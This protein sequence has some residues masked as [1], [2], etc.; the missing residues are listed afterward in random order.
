MGFGAR[1]AEWS[2]FINGEIMRLST[3]WKPSWQRGSSFLVCKE[4][5]NGALR[6]WGL[7]PLRWASVWRPQNVWSR[8]R[9]FSQLPLSWLGKPKRPSSQRMI[10]ACPRVSWSLVFWAPYLGHSAAQSPPLV[11]VVWKW[12]LVPL[13]SSCSFADLW[14]QI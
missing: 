4:A 7:D 5:E 14:L 9:V 2:G 6:L 12:S 11:Q 13:W 1:R 10:R 8:R 3:Q